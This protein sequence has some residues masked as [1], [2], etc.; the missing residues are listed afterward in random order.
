M[1]RRGA[2]HAECLSAN[3]AGESDDAD[4]ERGFCSLQGNGHEPAWSSGVG[5]RLLEEGLHIGK[6]RDGSVP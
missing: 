6:E 5:W 3:E 2:T 4:A 1:T